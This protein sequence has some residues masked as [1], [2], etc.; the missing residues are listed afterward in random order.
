[1]WLSNRLLDCNKSCMRSVAD[2]YV[3]VLVKHQ[4]AACMPSF[5]ALQEAQATVRQCLHYLQES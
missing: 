4:L 2:P 3:G 5:K 1:M